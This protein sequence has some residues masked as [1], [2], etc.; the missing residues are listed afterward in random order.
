M[1]NNDMNYSCNINGYDC[2]TCKGCPNATCASRKPLLSLTRATKPFNYN[3]FTCK[4]N[5]F[6]GVDKSTGE[7][8]A[9]SGWEVNGEVAV[10]YLEGTEWH[11]YWM[12]L[13][14]CDFEVDLKGVTLSNPAKKLSFLDWLEEYEGITRHDWDENYFGD[15]A[16]EEERLYQYYLLDNFPLF[17][18]QALE[19]ETDK[20]TDNNSVINDDIVII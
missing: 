8:I 17:V 9:T 18:G 10:Y 12:S 14:L 6:F 15:M 2:C 7:L 3:G 1:N 19:T 20:E 5:F 11:L 16:E 4:Q 13:N